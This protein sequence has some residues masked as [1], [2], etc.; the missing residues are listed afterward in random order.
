VS[1]ALRTQQTADTFLSMLFDAPE[2]ETVEE[3]SANQ[4]AAGIMKFLE[5]SREGNILLV[6]HNPILSELLALL[7]R[8][9]IDGLYI[10]ETANLACVSLDIIGLGMGNCPW[11]LEPD[12]N[13][14]QS[15]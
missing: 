9:N 15:S 5:P 13:Q 8:G 11:I 7:T 10:L 1:P 14:V 3:L 4:R 6:S 12:P 2:A